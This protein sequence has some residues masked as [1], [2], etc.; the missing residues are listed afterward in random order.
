MPITK[1]AIKKQRQDKTRAKVNEPIRGRVKSNIKAARANP[2][3][4]SIASLYSAVDHAVAKKL[5]SLRTAGR[6]KSRLVKMARATVT[7]SPFG[8]PAKVAK[9]IKTPK[10]K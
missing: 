5:M 4:A 9:A 8:K 1:S 6:L 2:T 3:P 7:V 10:A